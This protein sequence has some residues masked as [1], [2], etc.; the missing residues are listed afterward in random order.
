MRASVLDR[1]DHYY[2]ASDRSF[3]PAIVNICGNN[4]AI[5][6]ERMQTGI[7]VIRDNARYDLSFHC[8]TAFWQIAVVP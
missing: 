2:N 3:K 5:F 7:H 6:C 8:F 4:S 1:T